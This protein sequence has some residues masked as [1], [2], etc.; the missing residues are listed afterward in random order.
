MVPP[1]TPS[2]QGANL[3]NP[4]PVV[5]PSTPS[6]RALSTPI[7]ATSSMPSVRGSETRL[8][9]IVTALNDVDLMS[10]YVVVRGEKPGV[11]SNRFVSVLSLTFFLIF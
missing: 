9:A 11:Y 6:R 8:A 3:T 7:R 4:I 10:H 2:L 1:T 5:Q